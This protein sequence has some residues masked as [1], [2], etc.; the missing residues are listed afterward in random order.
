VPIP[1]PSR[2]FNWRRLLLPQ[3]AAATGA[4]DT[5]GETGEQ[6]ITTL[7]TALKITPDEDKNLTAVA[8]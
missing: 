4:T 5:K 6:R 2:H 7:H 1:L 8:Q 3:S